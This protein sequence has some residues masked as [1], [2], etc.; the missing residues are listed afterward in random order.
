MLSV[1]VQEIGIGN[2]CIIL[3]RAVIIT[4]KKEIAIIF[5]LKKVAANRKKF[6]GLFYF[7]KY[8]GKHGE[9]EKAETGEK[10]REAGLSKN[11]K[12]EGRSGETGSFEEKTK[13]LI[14]S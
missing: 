10:E 12:C 3:C 8:K 14:P 13:I 9:K 5:T 4:E 1:S 11:V 6:C 2:K 7:F